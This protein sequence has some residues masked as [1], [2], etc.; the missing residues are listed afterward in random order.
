M[1]VREYSYVMVPEAI[2]PYGALPKS[3]H[4][5]I[6]LIQCCSWVEFSFPTKYYQNR[7]KNVEVIKYSYVMAP[8]VIV[9]Y[10][11]AAQKWP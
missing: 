8:Q 6:I 11:A 10:G 9:P 5:R 2:V 1:E 7:M 4:S 3:D